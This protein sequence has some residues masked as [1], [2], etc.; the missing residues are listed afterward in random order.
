MAAKKGKLFI[1]VRHGESEKNRD[2]ILS[3]SLNGWPLTEK[4]KK[5]ADEAGKKLGALGH[6]DAFYSSPVL[7]AL[8]TAQI[9]GVHIKM[10]PIIDHRLRERDFGFLEER[11]LPGNEGQWKFKKEYKMETW[12]E[13][14]MK[15]WA[16]MKEANGGVV[17][18]VT[19]GDNLGVACD[20]MDGR[21]EQYHAVV[22][23]KTCHFAI[24]DLG[25]NVLITKDTE[26]IPEDLV[27][28]ASKRATV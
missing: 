14:K 10:S 22:L 5:Q 9:I 27:G 19:H 12:A 8:Q 3:S 20:L 11:P 21:G 17:V 13:L 1:F 15:M 2:N 18:V 6:I 26:K 23:T 16:F 7:R 4:G 24:M 25:K 28:S